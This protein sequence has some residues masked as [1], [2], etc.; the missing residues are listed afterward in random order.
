MLRYLEY[1]RNDTVFGTL[2]S[3]PTAIFAIL[4]AV[5]RGDEYVDQKF[6]QK[7]AQGIMAASLSNMSRMQSRGGVS[8][9][10][11]RVELFV[12]QIPLSGLTMLSR[13]LLWLLS[14]KGALSGLLDI[15]PK[16][17]SSWCWSIRRVQIV[18]T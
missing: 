8:V 9:G 12:A 14:R 16:D 2:S 18:E 1:G 5:G 6:A 15:C 10:E 13:Y 4:P 11:V 17:V 7:E 3:Y